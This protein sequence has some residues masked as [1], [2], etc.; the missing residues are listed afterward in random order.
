MPVRA[1]PGPEGRGDLVELALGVLAA[2]LRSNGT[3]GQY[4][5]VVALRSC[6]SQSMLPLGR[7]RSLV[8]NRTRAG[9]L[10]V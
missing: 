9:A 7:H 5:A 1:G 8:S 10:V 4:G 3:S 2:Q 6:G